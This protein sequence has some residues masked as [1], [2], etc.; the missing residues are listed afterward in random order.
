MQIV[1]PKQEHHKMLAI[2]KADD[3]KSAA[4]SHDSLDDAWMQSNAAAYLGIALQDERP[5]LCDN[6][7]S[8][9]AACCSILGGC[10]LQSSPES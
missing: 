10:S 6:R 8:A 7:R 5:K 4:A 3:N 9:C 2:A 1:L